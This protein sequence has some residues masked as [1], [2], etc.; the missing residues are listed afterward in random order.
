MQQLVRLRYYNMIDIAATSRLVPMMPYIL[1]N[2]ATSPRL[3]WGIIKVLDPSIERGMAV[4]LGRW[5]GEPVIGLRW[6]GNDVSPV[7]HPQSRGLATWFI[8][9]RGK[10]TEAIIEALPTP[11]RELVRNFISRN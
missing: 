8:V 1:P 9:E 2:Q 6:N 5:D 7:G 4:A 10:F 11:E 3:N